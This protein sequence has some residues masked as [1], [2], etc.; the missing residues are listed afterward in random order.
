AQTIRQADAIIDYYLEGHHH[1]ARTLLL[2]Q[3]Q[4]FATIDIY[5]QNLEDYERKVK[6]YGG[7]LSKH[8]D[9]SLPYQ[10][11]SRLKPEI[12]FDPR[13]LDHYADIQRFTDELRLY[14]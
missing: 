2:A 14:R 8:I 10:A 6:R 3:I 7:M 11:L 4:Q 13:E 1:Q 12:V 9:E 5:R